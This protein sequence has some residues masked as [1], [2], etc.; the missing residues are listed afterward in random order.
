MKAMG[1]T[2]YINTRV[3]P[4]L[5][6]DAETV[7]SQLGLSMSDAVALFLR[8]SVLNKGL[9][10]P[11]RLPNAETLEAINEPRENLKRYTSSQEMFDDILG[12][13]D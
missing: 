1:K 5:K 9:P 4:D 7:F 3:E 12:E 2:A 8:Q 13:D 11:V 6:K 10:F